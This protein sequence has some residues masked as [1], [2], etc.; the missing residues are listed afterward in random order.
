MITVSGRCP[1]PNMRSLKDSMAGCTIFSKIDLV[2]AY[3]QIPIAEAD[4]PKTA[5]ATPFDLFEFLF[6]AFGLKKNAAQALQ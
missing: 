5:T 1:L 3:H 2:K 4:V 6:M